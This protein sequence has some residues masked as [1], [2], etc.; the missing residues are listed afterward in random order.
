MG[1]GYETGDT[2]VRIHRADG[3]K[4]WRPLATTTKRRMDAVGMEWSTKCGNRAIVLDRAL[5]LLLE[6]AVR[7]IA[8]TNL[9]LSNVRRCS[10][11]LEQ[12]LRAAYDVVEK[13]ADLPRRLGFGGG[14]QPRWA[15][16]K[17]GLHLKNRGVHFEHTHVLSLI[18]I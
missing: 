10:A 4:W 11:L 16:R 6:E 17:V 13:D 8:D 18:H 14:S 9:R 2:T 3:L 7:G 1:F 15:A 5:L 12:V